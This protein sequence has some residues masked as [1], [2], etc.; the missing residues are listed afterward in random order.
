MEVVVE[1]V[2]ASPQVGVEE[3]PLSSY[4]TVSSLPALVLV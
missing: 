4:L 2:M 3:P 1:E